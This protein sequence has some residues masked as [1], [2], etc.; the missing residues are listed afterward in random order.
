[1]ELAEREGN[2]IKRIRVKTVS[3]LHQPSPLHDLECLSCTNSGGIQEVCFLEGIKQLVSG[4]VTQ[5]IVEG[6]NT[7]LK[8]EGN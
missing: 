3:F 5:K 1:M 4:L 8:T 7:A 2:K 6:G